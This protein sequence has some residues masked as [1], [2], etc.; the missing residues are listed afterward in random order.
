MKIGKFITFNLEQWKKETHFIEKVTAEVIDICTDPLG[1]TEPKCGVAFKG[2]EYGIP[3]SEI[4]K[5][6]PATGEQL[7]FNL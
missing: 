5:V 1:I 4:L 3:F 6:D 2:E 7:T